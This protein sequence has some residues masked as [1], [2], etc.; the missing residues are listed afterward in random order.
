MLGPILKSVA[1]AAGPSL[2]RIFAEQAVTA[3]APAAVAGVIYAGKK[4]YENIR[5]GKYQCDKCGREFRGTPGTDMHCP[6]CGKRHH[7]N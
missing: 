1:R 4:I 3:A 2:G 5:Q 7:L 6:G